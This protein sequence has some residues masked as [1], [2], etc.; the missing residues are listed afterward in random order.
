MNDQSSIDHAFTRKLTEIIRANLENENFGV[1][2]LARETGMSR[3]NLNRKLHFISRKT[4]NQFIREV[5]L[6]RAMEM[7][8]QES[9]TASEVSNEVGFSSPAYFSIL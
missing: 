4:I 6:E 3:F 1:K 2:E 9:V 8:R 7:L 5:R